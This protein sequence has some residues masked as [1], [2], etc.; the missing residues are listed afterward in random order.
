MRR[1][2][3]IVVLLLLFFQATYIFSN[4]KPIVPAEGYLH[5]KYVTEEE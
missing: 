5:D 2:K 1:Y 4:L 3:L